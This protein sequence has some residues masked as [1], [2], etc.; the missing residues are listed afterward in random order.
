MEYLLISHRYIHNPIQDS[1][2][3][4]SGWMST[5]VLPH[6]ITVV[7]S[8]KAIIVTS[9]CAF[10]VELQKTDRYLS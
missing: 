5:R 3:K 8:L 10:P 4:S 7:K 6:L 2:F 9:A 1:V